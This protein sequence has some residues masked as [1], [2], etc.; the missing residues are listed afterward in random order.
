M[1]F[2]VFPFVW[3]RKS[4]LSQEYRGLVGKETSASNLDMKYIGY[5]A[6]SDTLF[7]Q[8]LRFSQLTL[9]FPVEIFFKKGPWT[10]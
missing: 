8:I 6:I 7:S 10:Q 1:F 3:W 5:Q 2:Y 4:K 9:M